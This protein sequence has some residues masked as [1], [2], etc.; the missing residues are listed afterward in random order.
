MVRN[1]T[2]RST[3]IV[4]FVLE[5]RKIAMNSCNLYSAVGLPTKP[6]RTADWPGVTIN[7]K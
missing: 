2:W 7:N 4:G 3:W 1:T 5:K 6:F